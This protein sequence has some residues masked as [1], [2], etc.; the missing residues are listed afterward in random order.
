MSRYLNKS[1]SVLEF[2][3]Q[4]GSYD[5]TSGVALKNELKFAIPSEY[6]WKQP[7]SNENISYTLVSLIKHDGDSLDFGHY[8]SDIF[9]SITGT[10]WH[11]DDDSI[12]QISDLPKGFYYR[13]THKLTKKKKEINARINRFIFC[14]LYQNK[15]SDKTQLYFFSIIHNHVKNHSYEE[16]N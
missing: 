9:D 8:V 6:L 4:R 13:E 12:T 5:I 7:S 10:W 3:F 16:S 14:C 15:P 1:P 2:L 11:C